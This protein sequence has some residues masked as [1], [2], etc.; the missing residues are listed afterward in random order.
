M[1]P[2][3][4]SGA[5]EGEGNKTADASYRKGATEFAHSGKVDAGAKEA[6]RAVDEDGEELDE[7]VAAGR[8]P[9]A[10]DLKSDLRGD[11]SKESRKPKN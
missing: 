7:A 11:K 9:S 10:G 4:K 1:E 3:K 6:A 2:N 8:K 5:N